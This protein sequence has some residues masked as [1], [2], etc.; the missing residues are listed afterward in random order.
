MQST[1]H[2]RCPGNPT[3]F[4]QRERRWLPRLELGDN[5]RTGPATSPISTTPCRRALYDCSFIAYLIV[6]KFG[7]M[8]PL[9]RIQSLLASQGIHI[10]TGTMVS[11]MER[12]AHLANAVDGEH[13]KQLNSRLCFDGTGRKVLIPGQSTAWDGYLEMYTRDE[14]TV[15]Q[16]DLTK[17]AE[18][19]KKRRAAVT[20]TLVTDAESRNMA[21]APGATFTHCNAHVVRKLKNARRVQ[22]ELANEELVLFDALYKR[23]ALEKAKGPTGAEKAAWR[24]ASR[25]DADALF[26]RKTQVAEGD[27]PP[28]DPVRK[29]AKCYLRH[30]DGLTR[31]LDDPALPIDNSA[32]ER[33]FQRHAK[34][35]LASLFAGSIEGAHRWA[36]L[37]GIVRTA[38]KHDL[39]VQAYLTL[40]FER[41]ATHR[42]RFGLA[43]SELTP[44]AYRVAGR[45]GN[46]RTAPRYAA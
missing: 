19:L 22:P 15:F 33:E 36:T 9:D 38:Q 27:L 26:A 35:R 17:D 5:R 11:L 29:A 8:M 6:M 12:A 4:A 10:A 18:E 1:A 21:G 34:L 41:R 7:L 24:Q 23:E 31:F 39:H 44:A 45:P 25:G 30:R 42:D 13:M 20:A 3:P 28:S 16:F 43:A 32:A 37:L 2:S 14:T 40:L 46:L